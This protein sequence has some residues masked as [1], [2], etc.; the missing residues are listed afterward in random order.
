MRSEL[1]A[2]KIDDAES[3]SE[4]KVGLAVVTTRVAAWGA[5]MLILVPCLTTLLSEAV[6]SW[7][8]QHP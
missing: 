2:H 7:L 5:A 3:F 6:R 8:T 4:V 1:T